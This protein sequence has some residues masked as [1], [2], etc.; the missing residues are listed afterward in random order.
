MSPF[1]SL[2]HNNGC[3]SQ[4]SS[5]MACRYPFV[6]TTRFLW[7]S[8]SGL[9]SILNCVLLF[10]LS[11]Y[12]STLMLTNAWALVLSTQIMGAYCSWCNLCN[13]KK[14]QLH[15]CRRRCC[16]GI[17]NHR[18]G[19]DCI[20][21]FW[22]RTATNF[23]HSNASPKTKQTWGRGKK[24]QWME[25]IFFCD[26]AIPHLLHDYYWKTMCFGGFSVGQES[27]P[28]LLCIH[29]EGVYCVSLSIT[30]HLNVGHFQ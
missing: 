1:S 14:G 28:M 12:K 17:E 26:L 23:E 20:S 9:E 18:H 13:W 22:C 11:I 24:S 25:E 27:D 3:I 15:Y 8:M 29:S 2:D 5:N 30:L 19:T 6:G 10:L 4:A 16:Y 21:T 7:T